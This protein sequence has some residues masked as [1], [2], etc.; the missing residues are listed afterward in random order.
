M[1]IESRSMNCLLVIDT[2]CNGYWPQSLSMRTR[3]SDVAESQPS[4]AARNLPQRSSSS[5]A[6]RAS[7][8]DEYVGQDSGAPQI[9]RDGSDRVG[10]ATG[11]SD[12]VTRE[13]SRSPNAE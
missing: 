2:R 4:T 8:L 6:A 7:S 9:S 5:A 10:R 12:H 11:T 13:S 1:V 3:Q